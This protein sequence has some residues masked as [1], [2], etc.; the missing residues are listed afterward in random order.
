MRRAV[1][2]ILLALVLLPSGARAY[3]PSG[4]VDA[5]GMLDYRQGPRFR[6]GDWV[7]Y[8]TKGESAQGFKTD[9]TVTILIAGEELWWGEKCFWVETQTRYGSGTLEIAASL[10]S[11]SVFGDT[12][13][14]R[15]F[16]RYIRKFTEGEDEHGHLLQQ[17]FMR[18]PS[19]LTQ[20]GYGEYEP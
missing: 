15:H 5:V 17:P 13:P 1:L 12:L 11:Y 20:R 10:L 9:Y 3:K 19:E 18:A 2:V 7:R 14:S 16:Q 4:P 6:V 8:H